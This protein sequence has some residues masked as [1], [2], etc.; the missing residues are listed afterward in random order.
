MTDH[1]Q[2]AGEHGGGHGSPPGA[3]GPVTRPG[4]PIPVAVSVRPE[5][6]PDLTEM[7]SG[8]ITQPPAEREL[9]ARALAHT[10][11]LAT[12]V[13]PGDAYRIT[14]MTAPVFDANG[15]AVL[16]LIVLGPAYDLN[17]SSPQQLPERLFLDQ[18]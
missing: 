2:S 12:E 1:E 14:Q 8:P 7:L 9:A 13:V 3:T 4:R 17:F 5:A 16:G 15:A 11:Y 10:E 18:G 6:R